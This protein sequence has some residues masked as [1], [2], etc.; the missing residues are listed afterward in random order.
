MTTR[1]LRYFEDRLSGVERFKTVAVL[2]SARSAPN[3]S[4]QL[5]E[6]TL[7]VAMNNAWRAYRGYSYVVYADDFPA[8]AKPPRLELAIRGRSSA[9]Y[10]PAM[11]ARGGLLYCGAS[12]GFAAGY[13]A[14]HSLPFSQ[15]SYYAADM[16]YSG[17]QTHFYGRGAPDP[18]RRDVSLQDLRA[19]C[20]RLFYFGLR[21]GCLLLNASDAPETR[22]AYPR[23]RSGRSLRCNVM[24]GIFGA[25][26]DA[27]EEMRPLAEDALALEAAAPFDWRAPDYWRFME[28]EV[29][30][31]HT[32]AVDRR[33]ARLAPHVE[34]L[35]PMINAAFDA[36][37][38]VP[39]AS[40]ARLLRLAGVGVGGLRKVFSRG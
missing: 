37:P 4:R 6:D 13:W 21:N 3:V 36:A 27:L 8:S 7:L 33:W 16:R 22:L 29:A 26:E 14:I 34:Q 39:V 9:Q 11:T 30:W 40:R 24:S 15:I 25:L 17:A 10:W 12:I 38:D 31:E 32:A 20:L 1:L 18:L 2:G 35:E 5:G 23:V 19:K 28:D